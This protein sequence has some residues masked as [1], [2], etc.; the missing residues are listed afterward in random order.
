MPP[1]ESTQG[2]GRQESTDPKERRVQSVLCIRRSSIWTERVSVNQLTASLSPVRQA[3]L[4][5]AGAPQ[6]GAGGGRARDAGVTQ[7][8]RDLKVSKD[9][10]DHKVTL[11]H[12]DRKDLK[13]ILVQL[14][15]QGR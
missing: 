5:F 6:S 3:N 2:A 14:D 10:Q 7:A 15:R 12:R 1:D 13:A 8:Q 9:W 11:D 4:Q